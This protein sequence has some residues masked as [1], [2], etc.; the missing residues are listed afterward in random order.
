MRLA[1]GSNAIRKGIE[2]FVSNVKR[3]LFLLGK[4]VTETRLGKD[5]LG[6]IRVELDLF[7]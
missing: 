7:A 6:S 2:E 3:G 5:L 4:H 1:D